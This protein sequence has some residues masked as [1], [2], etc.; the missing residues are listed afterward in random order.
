ME[1][2]LLQAI[3]LKKELKT[4]VIEINDDSPI[5]EDGNATVK[6]IQDNY[7]FAGKEFIKLIED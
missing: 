3:H 4:R 1:K 5:I 2:N 6:F 7:G